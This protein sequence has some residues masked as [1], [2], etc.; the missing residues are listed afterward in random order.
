MVDVQEEFRRALLLDQCRKHKIISSFDLSDA[1]CETL[2]EVLNVQS[3]FDYRALP[4]LLIKL[5]TKFALKHADEF[6]QLMFAKKGREKYN[7]KQWLDYDKLEVKLENDEVLCLSNFSNYKP[8]IVLVTAKNML[9]SMVSSQLSTITDQLRTNNQKSAKNETPEK[10]VKL[11]NIKTQEPVKLP[12]PPRHFT[13]Y[14]TYNNKCQEW[15]TASVN[16]LREKDPKPASNS[17]YES[18]DD[19]EEVLSVKTSA[20]ASRTSSIGQPFSD[21]NSDHSFEQVLDGCINGKTVPTTDDFERVSCVMDNA[22]DRSYSPL[23]V[24]RKRTQ[25]HTS[26]N[27]ILE[28]KE[29]DEAT[30]SKQPKLSVGEQHCQ[31][32]NVGDSDCQVVE[33]KTSDATTKDN[34]NTKRCGRGILTMAILV[35][36]LA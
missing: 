19:I 14:P 17:N 22:S 7:L 5:G 23:E 29:N 24:S 15:D 34:T 18:N 33:T 11:Q 20:S 2:Q 8:N 35:T 13:S 25:V 21:S 36:M 16:S 26:C 1:N 27:S 3:A 9:F 31:E 30:A 6:L 28:V 10:K 4:I 32:N 12:S